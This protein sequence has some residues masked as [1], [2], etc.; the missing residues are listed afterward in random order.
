MAAP[1]VTRAIA[2]ERQRREVGG[3]NARKAQQK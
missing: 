3:Y 1:S 2:A